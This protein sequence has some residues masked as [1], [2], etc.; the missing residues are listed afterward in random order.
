MI[1]WIRNHER[2]YYKSSMSENR[3]REIADDICLKIRNGGSHMPKDCLILKALEAERKAGIGEGN[4][5]TC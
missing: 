4:E 2:L 5:R 3:M 1:R